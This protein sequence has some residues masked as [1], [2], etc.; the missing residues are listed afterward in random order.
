MSKF[1]SV[2]PTL[3]D[4]KLTRVPHAC[5]MRFPFWTGFIAARACF[6]HSTPLATPIVVRHR[7][8]P[9]ALIDKAS[10]AIESIWL[11]LY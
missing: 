6:L 9:Y 10:W 4:P 5:R 3:Q 8:V 2:L 11:I 1:L 7:S